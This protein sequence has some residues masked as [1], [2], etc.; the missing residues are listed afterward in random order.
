MDDEMSKILYDL[1]LCRFAHVVQTIAILSLAHNFRCQEMMK[2]YF[3]TKPFQ[4][5][6]HLSGEDEK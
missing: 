4:P 6:T 5:F 1:A 2:P 3:G